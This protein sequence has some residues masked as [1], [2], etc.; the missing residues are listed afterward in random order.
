MT[1]QFSHHIPY[2]PVPLDPLPNDAEALGNDFQR[3]LSYHLGRFQGCP[4]VYLYQALAYTL[5]DRLMVNWRAT[6]G[7]YLQQGRRRAYYMS[8]EFLIGRSLGNNLL[9]L[10]ICEP[11]KSALLNYCT[12]LEEVSSQEPDAGL[13]NGGLGRLAACFMD[14]CAT[15]GLPVVGYGIRYEYGMF[16]QHIENGYQI[17]DPDHWLRDPNPWE[18]E[19]AEYSQRVQFGGYT[20][21]FLDHSGKQ[22]VR[23]V[24]SNDVLAVPFDMPISGYKNDTVNTLRLW[25]ATATD[26][27]NLDEFNAGSYTEAVEA[28]NHAEHISMVLYPNDSSENGK[29]LRLRQQYFLASASLKDAIRLWERQ[30]NHDYTKFAAEHVFQMNDTH[31]TIAVAELMRILMD[32][33]GL[34]WDDAWAITSNCMAYTNHTLLPEALERWAV[35]LFAKLLP[36]LLEI[37]YEIN[38]RFLRQVA[39]KWPGDTE[40]QRRM[41]IIE[42]GGS[43]QVRMAWLAIVG[44]FSVNGVAALHSQLLVDGLFHDFYELWPDK[45]NNKTNGVTPRRWVAHANPGMTAL[46]S[47]HLGNDWVRDLSQ[48]E[49]LKPLAAPEYTAFHAQW[50]EVKYANKQR[51]AALVKQEC[52]VDFNPNA[53]FDVQ[54][55]RIHEYKRQ[56]LNLL[57]VVHL[58]RRIKL[59]KLDN[60]ADRCVLIGGKAAPGYAMAKRII[61]LINSV[62]EVVNNDPDVDGRLKVAFIP[63]YRVSSMEIIAPAANLSE[64]I[65]TAGKEASGTGNMKFMMNGALTIGTYDGANIEILEAVGEPNF[66]LF[67]LRDKDVEELR[68]CYRP[69]HYVEQ[70]EDLRGVIDLIRSGHFNMTE[71][72][73]FDMVLDAILSPHDPWMTLADFRSYVNAQEQVSV[74]WQDQEHWTRMSILNTASSGFFSTDRTMAEYNRDI[75]KL[76]P[77]NGN[78]D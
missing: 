25:K 42:E 74:A 41:S 3:Y 11:T 20:E 71:P 24:G 73:I 7:D 49:K 37:I 15:L 52:G 30:G 10:D 63:N 46:I 5:R 43:Q 77:G 64:Q 28:K 35:H 18:V 44:S 56:L 12:D 70:D 67:G 78:G 36:R 61:K 34:G 1:E 65:S 23:W 58:Y 57:H 6:W 53:L 31:P 33:K 66:F 26:E 40:R 21:H 54:V 2:V 39:M 59:G 55:K 75:W 68:H 38:A 76:K 60:W 72:G 45:F 8:L 48:L 69:W 16:R 19:R 9:N 22:R 27:F 47:E 17:E 13:G 51:L 29:E 4:S 50:R 62:A 14:S 32:E